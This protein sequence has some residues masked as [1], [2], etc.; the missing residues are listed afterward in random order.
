MKRLAISFGKYLI[1]GI[2]FTVVNVILMW[3]VIDILGLYSALGASIVVSIIF[4]AKFYTY[5]AIN[6]LK[7]NL[8]GYAIVNLSSMLLNILLVWFF[9]EIVGL[10]TISSSSLVVLLLFLGRFIAFK[11]LNLLSYD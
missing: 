6:F 4:I 11:K 7:K 8:L 3:F 1:V 5:V 10:T 2:I 9:I